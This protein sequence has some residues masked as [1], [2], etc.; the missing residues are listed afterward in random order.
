MTSHCL[1]S[2]RPKIRL[3][4][5]RLP[6][7]HVDDVLIPIRLFAPQLPVPYLS[8]PHLV[9][10]ALDPNVL[11]SQSSLWVLLPPSSTLA[12]VHPLS[13][14]VFIVNNFPSLTADP[15]V[16]LI[17]SSCSLESARPN[18]LSFIDEL[19]LREDVILRYLSLRRELKD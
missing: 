18:S 19:C 3:P 16:N 2:V 9:P 5:R 1:A 12:S 11:C 15:S 6:I 4:P 14:F 10:S 13:D 8:N 7:L 17:L